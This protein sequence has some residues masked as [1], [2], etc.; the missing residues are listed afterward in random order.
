MVR[1]DPA[2]VAAHQARHGRTKDQKG[3]GQVGVKPDPLA[4]MVIAG[5]AK[6]T[7]ARANTKSGDKLNKTEQRY[8]DEVLWPRHLAGEVKW[9]SAECV[10]RRIS[11]TGK[12]CWYRPDFEVML[13]D[14]S[15]E[16]HEIKGGRVEDDARVKF[17]AAM[18]VY[19]MFR[20]EMWAHIKGEWL[21][22]LDN[23]DATMPH[24]IITI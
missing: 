8:I 1:M 16:Y 21:L 19:P 20:W 7:R 2:D 9:F 3:A 17:L 14:G 12:R 4:D 15:I 13:A 18:R 11:T 23:R 10:S 22:K 5:N 24:A 6:G